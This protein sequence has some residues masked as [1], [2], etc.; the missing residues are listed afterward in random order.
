MRTLHAL[1]SLLVVTLLPAQE[2]RPA[3]DPA[4]LAA[5]TS[6]QPDDHGGWLGWSGGYT[7]SFNAD[8]FTY[9]PVL[10]NAAP[11]T[12]TW[13]FRC[14]GF[15]RGDDL[16]PAGRANAAQG[17]ATTVQF[18]RGG[19][20]ETYTV[21][22]DGVKQDFV[23]ATLPPGEGD[24]RVVGEVTTTLP[25]GDIG[26]D[27]MR[28]ELPGVGG[29]VLGAVLGIDANG[30]TVAGS[31]AFVDGRIEY[32]LPA[33]FVDRAALPLRLDPLV[34]TIAYLAYGPD[35]TSLDTACAEDGTRWAIVWERRLSATNGDIVG[36]NWANGAFVTG[37]IT[38]ESSLAD[39][40]APRIASLHGSDRWLV[41][42]GLG[43]SVR[44]MAWEYASS[45]ASAIAIT[46]ATSG[47]FPVVGGD[48]RSTGNIATVVWADPVADEVRLCPVTVSTSGAVTLGTVR[49]V[50]TDYTNGRLDISRTGGSTGRW[51]LS[52]P[53]DVGTISTRNNLL[54]RTW[55]LATAS[56][57]SVQ[58]LV[59]VG[60]DYRVSVD[61]DGTRWL[62]AYQMTESGSSSRDVF[63]RTIQLAG[64]VI[65]LGAENS[66][67]DVAAIDESDPSVAWLGE[68]ALV[69]YTT[70]STGTDLLCRV[71]S[72]EP[73]TCA[74]C[75]GRFDLNSPASDRA[76]RV[77]SHSVDGAFP[78]EAMCVWQGRA[79]AT[80]TI[81]A[82]T[83][84]AF[85][86]TDG[87][88]S[89]L[90]GGCG[91]GGILTAG[92][93]RSPTLGFA[94]SL[95]S[96]P[97]NSTT[98]WCLGFEAFSA[99]CGPCTLRVD[100]FDA[101][102]GSSTTDSTG[103]SVLSLQVVA[104]L[105]GFELRTQCLGLGSQCIGTFDLSNA[106]RVVFQ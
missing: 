38:I 9:T 3:F 88:V 87:S 22:S 36:V 24:L 77:A 103:A 97:A 8:G 42:F 82:V 72:I 4:T 47:Q 92:C 1:T 106:V 45:S 94:L 99:P 68:S 18:D 23:F 83:A 57:G 79:T 53:R 75:E 104:G 89:D 56:L 100:P 65:R 60:G 10:G 105:V 43:T 13:S 74:T 5:V 66:I 25:A 78:G 32:R 71:L 80:A 61:G 49:T 39:A 31:M 73:N 85:L 101:A 90:G 11:T 58:T 51:L 20:T 96:A 27:G 81:P 67:A 34:G 16:V 21:R 12:Q 76:A 86:G 91:A 54:A 62:A 17:D 28:F 6:L 55:T 48:S 93:A 69:A 70:Q 95:R 14:T 52:Y 2:L 30:D 15:G 26:P 7:A 63:V 59:A 64:S 29:V 50:S 40:T 33:S 35:I 102:V 41:T 84:Q 98:F 19:V 37:A 46:V 44:V